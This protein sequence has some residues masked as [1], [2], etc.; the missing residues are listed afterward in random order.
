MLYSACTAGNT[1]L[2]RVLVEHHRT[3]GG[4]LGR[5]AMP[6]VA[7]SPAASLSRL[8]GA[9]MAWKPE[10]QVH[11]V[12]AC[13]AANH[14][15]TLALLL[16]CD[17]QDGCTIPRGSLLQALEIACRRGNHEV[18]AMLLAVPGPCGQKWLLPRPTAADTEWAGNDGKFDLFAMLEA[19]FTQR[20]GLV[21]R[22]LLE[23]GYLPLEPLPTTMLEQ[24]AYAPQTELSRLQLFC[25]AM[26][27]QP[28]QQQKQVGDALLLA[29]RCK[30][31]DAV[32]LMISAGAVVPPGSDRDSSVVALIGRQALLHLQQKLQVQ[33]KPEAVAAPAGRMLRDLS[34]DELVAFLSSSAKLREV[35]PVLQRERVDGS[36]LVALTEADLRELG[37][38]MGHRKN[39]L[40]LIADAIAG[41]TV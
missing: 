33:P 3:R 23:A 39:M 32:K 40:T 41:H 22:T 20:L 2:A 5:L 12:W 13:A 34:V 14:T 37:L 36:A 18:A 35:A 30:D 11:P 24:P 31:A 8:P 9:P 27:E 38:P 1:E 19:V 10:A 16:D 29:C 7:S 17:R 6:S 4:T 26:G 15:D 21:V 25:A 28:A